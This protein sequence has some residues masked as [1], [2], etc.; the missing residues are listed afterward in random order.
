MYSC[1]F[2][3]F[4]RKIQP[5]TFNYGGGLHLANQNQNQCIRR[6]KGNCK[7]CYAAVG[8]EDFSVSGSGGE[9]KFV[10]KGCCSYGADGKY[11]FKILFFSL[12][13]ISNFN[14]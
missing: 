3:Q 5:K 12:D 9:K 7:I 4:H 11:V 1:K 13:L 2:C 14:M 8:L 6:E 10:T